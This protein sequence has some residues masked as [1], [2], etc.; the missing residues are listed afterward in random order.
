MRWLWLIFLFSPLF[1][2]EITLE[3][4]VGQLFMI[5]FDPARSIEHVAEV[6]DVISKY[7]IGGLITKGT[8]CQEHRD[9]LSTLQYNRKNPLLVS[10]DAEWGVNMRMKDC[11][12][13]PRNMTVGAISYPVHKKVG[14]EIGREVRLLGAQI[15]LGPVADVNTNPDNPVIGTRSF[16]DSPIRCKQLTDE[17]SSGI[18]N[19]GVIPTL[20]HFPGHGDVS[21]D[22]HYDLPTSYATLDELKNS[23]LIPFSIVKNRNDLAVMTAHIYYPN[24]G[25]KIATFSTELVENVLRSEWG[26][27][28]LIIT[29]ALNMKA[30]SNYFSI[31]EIAVNAVLAGHD[32]LLYGHHYPQEIDI[33][34]RDTI[35][36]AY[37][38]VLNA[39]KEGRISEQRLDQSISRIRLAREKAD[40]T[41]YSG[42]IDCVK[43]S[44]D[45]YKQAITPIGKIPSFLGKRVLTIEIGEGKNGLPFNRLSI[46]DQELPNLDEYDIVVGLVLSDDHKGIERFNDLECDHKMAILMTN[47][48]A[49]QKLK[50]MPTLVLYEN[51]EITQ[52]LLLEVVSSRSFYMSGHLPLGQFSLSHQS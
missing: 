20:K 24:V 31:E 29:D 48:Y 18:L 52:Q 39:V 21:V 1:A 30:L 46:M 42:Q 9:V 22:S 51:N 10:I 14:F 36:K 12:P 19:A 38:A 17:V 15:C 7:H 4:K 50:P 40:F 28:G 47:P 34:I 23:H 2:N 49:L 26:F 41:I 32:I 37:E 5:P 33:I 27:E 25:D 3:E 6:S 43:L 11:D 16:G 8:N 45:L 13:L 44:K 35:P